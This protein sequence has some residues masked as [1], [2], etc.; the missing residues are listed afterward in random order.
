[1]RFQRRNRLAAFGYNI[2]NRALMLALEARAAEF[3]V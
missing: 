2:E 1:V 3:P